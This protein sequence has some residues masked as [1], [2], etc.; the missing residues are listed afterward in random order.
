MYAGD[1]ALKSYAAFAEIPFAT[2]KQV[3]DE[4]FPEAILQPG[5]VMGVDTLTADAVTFKYIAAPLTSDQL[6]NLIRI[7]SPGK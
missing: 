1:D 3:R 2:A 4:F 7:P 6:A 5:E